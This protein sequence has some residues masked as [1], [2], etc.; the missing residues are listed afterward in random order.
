MKAIIQVRRG[1]ASAWARNNPILQ[2]GEIGYETDTKKLKIGDGTTAWQDLSFFQMESFEGTSVIDLSHADLLSRATSGVL[3]TG[4][5]Y[6]IN[7]FRTR[8]TM[9]NTNEAFESNTIEPLF[10]VASGP[11]TLFTEAFSELYPQDIIYYDLN[12][13]RSVTW[14]YQT[15]DP[16]ID[17]GFI[18]F[19]HDTI[20]DIQMWEDWRH[21]QYRRWYDPAWGN[22]VSLTD[23]GENYQDYLG[24]GGDLT[25]CGNVSIGRVFERGENW[26]LSNNV[27]MDNVRT[28]YFGPGTHDNTFCQDV[29]ENN[30]EGL[31]NNNFFIRSFQENTIGESFW[32]N[33]CW[34]FASNIVETQDDASFS[35]NTF[36]SDFRHNL[37]VW[38]FIA[39]RL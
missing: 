8:Y 23:N 19:R 24:F 21:N 22:Y 14:Q 28:S 39:T 3:D 37:S 38:I 20:L 1:L 13:G 29:D 4:Q 26:K 33:K 30:C 9:P 31:F 11:S 10:V 6:R 12:S 5:M 18:S 34:Y 7:D 35:G 25:Y 36:W 17:R 2:I 16:N 32:G 15:P 27:F